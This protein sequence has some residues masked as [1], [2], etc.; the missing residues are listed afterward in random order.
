M[1]VKRVLVLLAFVLLLAALGLVIAVFLGEVLPDGPG[2][3]GQFERP[4]G[5]A[6]EPA[7]PAPPT[8]GRDP[9]RA[10]WNAGRTGWV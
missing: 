2:S 5:Q 1:L 10:H 6:A 4:F 8:V 3:V 7:R 9:A